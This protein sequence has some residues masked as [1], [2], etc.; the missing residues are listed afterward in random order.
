[1]EAVGQLAAG[2]HDLKIIFLR[3]FMVIPSM[4]LM[5]LSEGPHARS[6]LKLPFG[7]TGSE[8]GSAAPDVQPSRSLIS[9]NVDLGDV[10]V[11]SGCFCQLVGEHVMLETKCDK[12]YLTFLLTAE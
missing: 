2:W 3:W 9:R 8:L 11:A 12:G 6:C 4:L 7:R 10:I 1:M 5:R